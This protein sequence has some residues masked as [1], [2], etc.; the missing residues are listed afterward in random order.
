MFLGNVIK[1]KRKD[2]RLTQGQ[3]AENIC[4]QYV[5][6]KI[7][8]HNQAPSIAV[9]IQLCLKLELTLND[10][11]S[12]FSSSENSESNIVLLKL[13]DQILM[14][15]DVSDGL[16][17]L[18][19]LNVEN[20]ID[21][22]KMSFYF[23]SGWFNLADNALSSQFDMDKLL[24]LTQTDSYNIYTELAYLVKGMAA[25]T[26]NDDTHALEYYK[27]IQ[28]SLQANS[29]IPNARYEQ[30]S[31]IFKV[32]SSF[33]CRNAEWRQ[34]KK[35]ARRGIELSLEKKSLLNLNHFYNTL[36]TAKKELGEEYEKEKSQ[37]ML[38]SQILEKSRVLDTNP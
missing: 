6:S 37:E 33:Y 26:Q 3:L 31:L 29:L 17:E 36:I 18:S 1:Q 11:F 19:L 5:I 2:K 7:E 24:R 38:L 9:L 13:E 30:L 35:I 21:N 32:L 10:V 12:D 20:L 14:D 34:T 25:E 15:D 23:L 22:E 4:R 8:K 28:D 16:S 27:M